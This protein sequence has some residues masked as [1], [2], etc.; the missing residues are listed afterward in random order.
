M[1]EINRV[2]YL[3][4][5]LKVVAVIFIFGIYPLTLIWPSG[6]AWHAGGQSE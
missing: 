4:I 5:V 6:W 3:S 1:G 2:K